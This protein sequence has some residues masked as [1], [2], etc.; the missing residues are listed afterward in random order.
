MGFLPGA[1]LMEWPPDTDR[2]IP[3]ITHGAFKMRVSRVTPA[4]R[5]HDLPFVVDMSGDTGNS[6][7]RH[8]GASPTEI[9]IWMKTA[10]GFRWIKPFS[11]LPRRSLRMQISTLAHLTVYSSNTIRRP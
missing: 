8:G 9:W 3:V 11:R 10:P 7:S 1:V 5:E 4:I 6:L 2:L